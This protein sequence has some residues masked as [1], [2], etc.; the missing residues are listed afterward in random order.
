MHLYDRVLRLRNVQ[1]SGWQRECLTWGS[2]L[3]AVLLA[4]TGLVSPWGIVVLPA[5][6]ASS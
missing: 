5:A 3:L 2:F 4:L 1:L 6:L